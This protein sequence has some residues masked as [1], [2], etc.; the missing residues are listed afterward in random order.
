MTSRS[1]VAIALV[2]VALVAG[3]ATGLVDDQ[4]PPTSPPPA[5]SSPAEGTYHPGELGDL[6]EQL[7][8]VQVVD[9]RTPT[10]GYDRSC[11]TDRGCNFGPAWSDDVE[12]EFGRNG[13]DTRNDVLARDLADVEHRPGTRDC[14][15]TAGTLD[16][17]YTGQ[18]IEFTKESAHEVHIDHLYSLARAW[19]LGASTWSPDRRRAFANDPI[20][21]LAVSGPANSSK[22][23]RG[24]GEWLPVNAGYRCTFVARYLD[25]AIAYDLPITR[26][27]HEAVTTIAPK[28]ASTDEQR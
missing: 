10:P 19:D 6:D 16:D 13:C 17:P 23:D 20:N 5:A 28:C 21:L 8:L 7:A 24:P 22:G 14:V 9:D 15:V 12:V 25:V 27:D 11:G 18:L 3:K 4:T 1:L 2:V 26:A